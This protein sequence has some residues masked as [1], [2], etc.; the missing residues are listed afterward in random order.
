MVSRGLNEAMKHFLVRGILNQDQ[1]L[2]GGEGEATVERHKVRCL[3]CQEG[4]DL[5]LT[6]REVILEGLHFMGEHDYPEAAT[7]LW[8]LV[9]KK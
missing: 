6:D 5:H 9:H 2:C 1:T 4:M 7:L 3:Q 8:E